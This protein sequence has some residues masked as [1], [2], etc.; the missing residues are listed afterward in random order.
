LALRNRTCNRQLER[1]YLEM[2]E[3]QIDAELQKFGNIDDAV[4]GALSALI[5]KPDALAR[6]LCMPHVAF[7]WERPIDYINS[8][9]PGVVEHVIAEARVD[10]S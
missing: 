8:N 4:V 9:A 10:A 5:R 7:G 1:V 6:W 3:Q 2:R